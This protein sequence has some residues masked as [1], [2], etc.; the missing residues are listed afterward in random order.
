MSPKSMKRDGE[1]GIFIGPV[2]LMEI[3]KLFCQ[4]Y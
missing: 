3:K 1:V 4:I 2:W